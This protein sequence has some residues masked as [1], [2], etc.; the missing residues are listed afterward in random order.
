MAPG[1]TLVLRRPDG[2]EASRTALPPAPDAGFEQALALSA[3]AAQGNWT[4]EAF[5][6]PSLPPVG[7]VAVSVMDFV[8]QQLKVA[9]TEA[10]IGPGGRVSAALDGRFLY[11][12]PATGLHAEGD[13]R[14]CAG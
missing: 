6:D 8:P 12:A 11:G 3:T 10:A 4:I 14:L 9:L 5:V 2:V 7:R 1:F 13:I